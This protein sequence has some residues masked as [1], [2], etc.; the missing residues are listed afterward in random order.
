MD[1]SAVWTS[2]TYPSGMRF[3]SITQLPSLTN[4]INHSGARRAATSIRDS[5]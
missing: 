4:M 5:D 1:L 2:S 3:V